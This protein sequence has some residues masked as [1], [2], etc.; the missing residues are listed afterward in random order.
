MK[1]LEKSPLEVW[2]SDLDAFLQQW[3]VCH[4]MDVVV[5]IILGVFPLGQLPRMGGQD[6]QGRQW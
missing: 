2:D 3:E 4:F 1:L 5:L 6:N